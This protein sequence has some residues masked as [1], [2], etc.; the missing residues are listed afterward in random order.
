VTL[1]QNHS[2]AEVRGEFDSKQ[3][4]ATV[5][6]PEVKR[7]R[8]TFRK[9]LRRLAQNTWESVGCFIYVLQGR[10]PLS[11]G[12]R[13]YRERYVRKS[14]RSDEILQ[15]FASNRTLPGG[16]GARLDERV[17]EYPWVLSR[18][19]RYTDKS[20]FLDA[21]ST[22]NHETILQ[23]PAVKGH[24]WSILTLSPETKCFWDLG[25]SYLFE[26]LRAVPFQDEW[27]DAVAC[28]S[29]IE[30]VGMDNVF[31]ATE[32]AYRENRPQDYLRAVRE[33][34]RIIRPGGSLFLS[35]PFGRYENHGWLQ[36]F[37]SH[38]LS[39]LISEFQPQ[40]VHKTF[41]YYTERGWKLAEEAECRDLSFSDAIR[42]KHSTG[43]NRVRVV[44]PDFAVAARAV[45]CI[46]LQK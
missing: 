26:D 23:H 19:S 43:K 16:Y 2:L 14:I 21:G 40:N 33:M 13:E 46:E 1:P 6:I 27:F 3:Q 32:Q 39:T 28:I 20:R 15:I 9:I 18:L 42:N 29:V 45:A 24:K 7:I 35:V 17:V 5:S 44:E 38:M 8:D 37:D 41:F 11:K 12:Y 25:V 10:L 34:R 31:F 36:Q 22:F 4:F 30:H